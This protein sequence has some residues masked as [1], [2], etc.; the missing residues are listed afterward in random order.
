MQTEEQKKE[1]SEPLGKILP[2]EKPNEPYIPPTV[3]PGTHRMIGALEPKPLIG[4]PSRP[5]GASTSLPN[6]Y[7]KMEVR[8][9][10][11][12]GFGVFATESIK[13]GEILEEVPVILWPRIQ[14]VTDKLYHILKDESF[15]SEEELH[16]EEVKQ[17]FG[18]KHPSKY[19]FKWFPPNTPAEKRT[20]NSYQCLPLGYGPIYNS[21]NGL[22]NASWEVKEK[23]M[24]FRALT[25]IEPEDEI[26]TFYG[27]MVCETGETFNTDEVFGF[28]LEYAAIGE[29]G[30]LGIL[31]RNL[32]FATEA[33]K[34]MRYKEAGVVQ[35][36][37]SLQASH[38]RI[39]I[40]R[41]S[42]IDDGE[43]KHSFDFPEPSAGFG[44]KFTFM[45]LKEFKQTR[46]NTIKF[47]IS[48][49]DI[50]TKKEVEKDVLFVNH[51]G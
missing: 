33:E 38:G 24:L 7:D 49:V 31:L 46:F 47:K 51:N 25:D 21:A 39:K 18:F 34:T 9:S 43:E 36:L 4:D 10:P 37:E 22:N 32:R 28:G 8:Q 42:V 17:M 30:Q 11:L 45:K 12:E 23:T 1:E 2:Q 29:S 20:G 48:Y 19:Y 16:R 50:K 44:L 26:F 27:Y 5:L 35:I 40:K 41:I 13:H 6:C 14:G 3:P 15:I